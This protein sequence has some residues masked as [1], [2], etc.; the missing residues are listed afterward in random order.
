MRPWWTFWATVLTAAVIWIGALVVGG[1]DGLRS[2]LA[3]PLGLA[4]LLLPITAA[5]LNLVLYRHQHEEVC[6]LEVQQHR[7]LRLIAGNGYSASM[8]AATGLALLALVIVTL[9]LQVARA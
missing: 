7:S 3:N 2:M 8:F 1:R 4:V 9:V 5:G 6:R